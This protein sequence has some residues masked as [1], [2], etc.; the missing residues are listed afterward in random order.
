VTQFILAF[1]CVS[2]E[3]EPSV[4]LFWKQVAQELEPLGKQLILLSTVKVADPA[5]PVIEIPFQITEFKGLHEATHTVRAQ[6][7]DV[8]D[9]VQ[10]Y[11][12][13]PEHALKGVSSAVGF[14]SD[15]LDALRPAAVIGWQSMNPVTRLVRR[16]SRE[17]DTPFW[18]AER[19]WFRGTLM[20]DLCENSGLSEVTQ[21]LPLARLMD[22]LP[23][24]PVK[25]EAERRRLLDGSSFARYSQSVQQSRLDFR[26]DHGIGSDASVAVLFTHGEPHLNR[27]HRD[28]IRQCHY[29]SAE[30]L[31]FQCGEIAID[32]YKRGHWLL[33]QE[34]P[35]NRGSGATL[36]LPELPTVRHVSST[37][38]TLLEAGDY[39]LFTLSTIQFDAALKRKRFGLL[40]NGI[41]AHPNGPPQ[42][43]RY[44]EIGDFVDAVL[45]DS[46]WKPRYQVLDQR[47]AFLLDHV[48]LGIH[49]DVVRRDSAVR[50][51]ESLSKLSSEPP[52]NSEDL[53][54][55]FFARHGSR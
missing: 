8:L 10:W 32:L 3:I 34:H 44:E 25:Y 2:S 15:L 11:R 55:G 52:F 35:F 28:S 46:A 14:F 51:V 37:V 9:V 7:P 21:C 6:D 17:R 53:L 33:V 54:D 36:R 49:D 13:S 42:I 1:H 24:D 4:E 20:V 43:W 39:F 16:L 48:L 29:T 38:D 40:S 22:R 47:M 30:Q 31:N 23:C 41:L 19:G 45:D 18:V 27:L 50:F 5:L 12:C 26:R